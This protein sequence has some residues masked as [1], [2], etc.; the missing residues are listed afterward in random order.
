[1][2]LLKNL[3]FE[4]GVLFFYKPAELFPSSSQLGEEKEHI[5]QQS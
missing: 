4:K 3:I 2:N 5:F 1:M